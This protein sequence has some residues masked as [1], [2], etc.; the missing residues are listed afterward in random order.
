[1]RPSATATAI[2]VSTSAPE[3]RAIETNLRN[4]P[5]PI[6]L[7]PFGDVRRDRNRGSPKLRTEAESFFGRQ[8]SSEAVNVDDDVHG[9]LPGIQISVRCDWLAGWLRH[10]PRYRDAS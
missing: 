3:P 4:S 9:K 6:R 10:V 8:C 1:M 7:W 2:C 5:P